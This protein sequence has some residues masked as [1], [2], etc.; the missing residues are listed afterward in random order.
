MLTEGWPTR[1]GSPTVDPAGPWTDDAPAVARLREHGAVLLGKT[2]TPEYGH[3]GVTDSRV[4]GITRNPW[5]TSR[6]PG[7]SSGGAA[8]ALAA[9]LGPLAIGTDGGGSI[10]IPASFSGV[11]GIKPTFGRVPAWPASPFG[12][13]SHVGP[14]ARCVAD[15]A[16]ML[17]VLA[18]PD[19]RDWH[20]LPPDGADYARD[21]DRPLRG[22]TVAWSRALGMSGAPLDP[23]TAAL[24]EAAARRFESLGATVEEADPEWPHEPGAVFDTYWSIGAAMLAETIGPEKAAALEP[25]LRKYV[26]A[27]RRLDGLAVKR[28]ELRRAGN[29]LAFNRLFERFDLVLSPTM[30]MPAFA[31][32]EPAPDD[33]LAGEPLRWTP[34]TFPINLT[35]NP[36][37]STPCGLTRA[38]LPVG[39]QVIGPLYGDAAVLRACRAC[40]RAAPLGRRAP[41]S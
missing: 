20:A 27:G 21:L 9:G 29:G 14:M 23:E 35:R 18:E 8:A 32:G 40:E 25:S 17:G 2:T 31:A 16:L 24:T 5:D 30:P 39:L 28:A 37:A 15:A 22:A 34:F 4:S 26:E 13:V 19:P 41:I 36:A 6:T 33:S 7:G 3:K 38:G 12:T 11:F 1:R 10:R